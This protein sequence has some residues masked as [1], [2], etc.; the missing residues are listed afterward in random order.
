M[1]EP[2]Y[3]TSI[4]DLPSKIFDIKKMIKSINENDCYGMRELTELIPDKL[5]EKR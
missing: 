4:L 3:K 2:M 5:D 1:K